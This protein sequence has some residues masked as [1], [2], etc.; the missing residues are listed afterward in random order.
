M[1]TGEDW[2]NVMYDCWRATGTGAV[3][4]FLFLIVIGMFVILN[5][6]LAISL[7]NFSSKAQAR[8]VAILAVTAAGKRTFAGRGNGVCFMFNCLQVHKCLR[9][10]FFS[11]R[12][13]RFVLSLLLSTILFAPFRPPCRPRHQKDEAVI[14]DAAWRRAQPPPR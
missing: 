5:L 6:F 3:V 1:L 12:A 2:N 7:S 8:A 10:F 9:L 4:Y 14:A 13:A 11:R